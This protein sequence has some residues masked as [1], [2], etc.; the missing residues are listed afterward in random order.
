MSKKAGNATP[1]D[2]SD[3]QQLPPSDLLLDPQNP[4]LTGQGF[5]LDQQNLILRYLW[6][7]KEVA[8][9][10]DSI[11]HNGYW[12]Q[13]VLFAAEEDGKLI[14]VEGNRR[15]AAVKLLQ[16]PD[17]CNEIDA[18][19]VPPSLPARITSTYEELPVIVCDR[20]A[21]WKYMGFKHLNGPQ[22]WD[23]I[24][25]AEYIARVHDDFKVSLV[26]VAM[27]SATDMPLLGVSTTGSRSSDKLRRRASSRRRTLGAT[28]SRILIS[29]LALAIPAYRSFLESG[30]G[31]R[32]RAAQS[33]RRTCTGLDS[34]ASGY[35]G[36]EI[37]R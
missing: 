4:R 8:E 33:P 18:R 3:V 35:L 15:L 22:E 29:G 11:A 37:L 1:I 9:L 27:P 21:L 17:L 16:S 10:V 25:K 28:G 6:Q 5:A 34:F 26:E 30:R 14:V 36:A 19:G 24:A 32:M 23:S 2:L 7:D 31:P 13:E 12:G 20:R